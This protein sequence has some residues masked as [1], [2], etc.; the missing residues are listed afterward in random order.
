MI[1]LTHVSKSYNRGKVKAVDDLTLT[2]SPGEIFGFLGPN[3]AGKTTTIKM[4]VGL[5][6]PDAG[7]ARRRGLRPRDRQ[8][9]G[10]AGDDLRPR[11]AG[12]LRAA[13]RP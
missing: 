12:G 11:H 6:R 7:P 4:L 1:E 5:L 3:G 8:P 10:Q 13:D 9:Q 2:V